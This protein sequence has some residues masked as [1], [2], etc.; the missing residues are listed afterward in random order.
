MFGKKT[1]LFEEQMQLW[2]RWRAQNFS[3]CLLKISG[4][5]TNSG[6]AK[7]FEQRNYFRPHALRGHFRDIRLKGGHDQSLHTRVADCDWL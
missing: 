7:G 1:L 4:G 3:Q 6:V 5:L 2:T